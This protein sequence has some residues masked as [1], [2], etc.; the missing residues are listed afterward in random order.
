MDKVKLRLLAGVWLSTVLLLVG[1]AVSRA[2]FD[3]LVDTNMLNLLP[4][5]QLDAEVDPIVSWF[6]SQLNKKVMFLVSHPSD[7]QSISALEDLKARLSDWMER[8]AVHATDISERFQSYAN[9]LYY[10]SRG[11]VSTE[12]QTLLEQSQYD[13]LIQ[14]SQME[15]YS[16]VSV[17]NSTLLKKDPFFFISRLLN[18][19]QQGNQIEWSADWPYI[20][21][22]DENYFLLSGRLTFDAFDLKMQT[23]FVSIVARWQQQTQD[24]SPEINILRTGTVFFAND[25][26]NRAKSEISTVGVG[27]LIAIVFL[28]LIVFRDVRVLLATSFC[29]ALSVLVATS[30]VVS[31]FTNIHLLA[32]VFGATLLGVSIDYSFHFFAEFYSK[33]D[34]CGIDARNRINKALLMGGGSSVLAY[35]S[36]VW[37]GFPGLQQI[38]VFS[39]VGLGAAYLTVT[40]VYPLLFQSC[41]EN[42]ISGQLPLAV[43][44]SLVGRKPLVVSYLVLLVIVI[45]YGLPKLMPNDD[46]RILQSLAPHLKSDQEKTNQIMGLTHNGGYFLVKAESVEHVLQKQEQLAKQVMGL[47]DKQILDNSYMMAKFVPSK[48]KQQ[49]IATLKSDFQESKLAQQYLKSIGLEVSQAPDDKHFLTVASLSGTPLEFHENELIY[50]AGTQFYGIAFFPKLDDGRRLASDMEEVYWI[51]NARDISDAFRIYRTNT[52]LM[53]SLAVLLIFAMFVFRY[54]FQQGLVPALVPLLG[55]L[56]TFGVLGIFGAEFN[57]FHLL[58]AMVVLGLGL[59]YAIFMKEQRASQGVTVVAITLSSLTTILAFGLLSFSDTPAVSAFGIVVLCGVLLTYT[60]SLLLVKVESSTP[61]VSAGNV[62]R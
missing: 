20:K 43:I 49:W 35:S 47:N 25:G 50:D 8:D 2:N 60:L 14:K 46:I 38:A 28:L 56:A 27:S 48:E 21:F 32:L 22:K 31:I 11:L 42:K 3:T 13:V 29:L 7:Q 19:T 4:G 34:M 45:L 12:D 55:C 51:D 33:K 9:T 5:Q 40:L 24:S 1:F 23:K 37:G 26:S 36:L 41:S 61:Y 10:H 53:L 30:V 6:Y 52:A 62:N 16:P 39:V 44:D 59:D 57:L 15:L 58:G 17:V 18:Q 54:G